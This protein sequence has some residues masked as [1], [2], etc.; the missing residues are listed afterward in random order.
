MNRRGSWDYASLLPSLPGFPA[1]GLG[2]FIS[3]KLIKTQTRKKHEKYSNNQNK[4]TAK[5]RYIMNISIHW[6]K[7]T[8]N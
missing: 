8:K 5:N 1:Y 7:K 2:L 6:D 3:T 4:P